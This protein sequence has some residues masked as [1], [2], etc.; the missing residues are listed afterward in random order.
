MRR[1][2][3]SGLVVAA[4]AA[5]VV[6]ATGATSGGNS[7]PT[8][9]I[10]LDN[11]FGLSQGEQ[12]KVAGVAAGKISKI[13]LDQRSLHAVVTVQINVGGFGSFHKDA[14]CESRPQTLIGEYFLNCQPGS[15]GPVLKSGATIP[16]TRTASTVPG[17]LLQDVM[18]MPYRERLTLIIN[19][20]GAGV[21]GNSEN[22]QAAL[23]RAVPALT[24]TDN[25]L[26]LL[27]N[28]SH[29]LQDL[30]TSSNTL[31]T[32]LAD[33]S[34][35]VQR[36]IDS[37]DKIS[38]DTAAQ[39]ASLKSTFNNLPPFLEQLR[40]SLAQLG[41]TVDA[42]EP[43]LRN[44]NTGAGEID[45][46]LKDIPPFSRSALPALRSLGQASVTGISAVK[47]ATPVVSHLNTFAA[48]TPELAGNL[49][50]VGH[51]LDDRSRAV[52]KDP[53][54]PGGQGYTGLEA[55]LQYVFNQTLNLDYLGSYGHVQAV[56]LFV[57]PQC[58]AL[59]TPGTI[60]N[61]LKNFGSSYRQCYSWLGPNQQGLNEPDPSNPG[62]CPPDPGGQPPYAPAGSAT[63]TSSGSCPAGTSSSARSSSARKASARQTTT[64]ASA[65]S[66]SA[67]TPGASSGQSTS[68]G[69]SG[70]SSGSSPIDLH[71]TVGQLLKGISAPTAPSSST[72]SSGASS[73]GSQSPS[74]SSSSATPPSSSTTA[75]SSS[76]A[77]SPNNAQQLLNY[78][79]AP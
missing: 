43:A 64:T 77:P 5:L 59:A 67:G 47:A 8:Y 60:A 76:S 15:S 46:L 1:V 3:I 28:D 45:R 74:S 75:T 68:S 23:Q 79:L 33:N 50:I 14:F 17:D 61:S 69:G 42:N 57:S 7:N 38:T 18:R 58:S 11:S 25:L 34:G 65:N 6:F 2:L 54:S 35:Q 13:D 22:L 72:S 48:Q 51:D 41:N 56:N 40:P 66:A 63:S 32:A 12:F 16:V 49:A 24:E 39:S 29:T 71:K 37:A 53:R 30:T 21:A 31:V 55:L 73:S 26:N 10:E 70:G 9:K 36:F 78:L 19:E 44:L 52:E 62:A 20:L 4:A 27:A